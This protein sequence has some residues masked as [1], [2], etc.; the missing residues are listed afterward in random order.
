M[1]NVTSFYYHFNFFL[2][3]AIIENGDYGVLLNYS[4]VQNITCSSGFEA[5]ISDCTVNDAPN[6]CLPWCPNR[7]I[8]LRCFTGYI[9]KWLV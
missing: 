6:S 7:N 2:G 8:G 1:T 3:G 9:I 4:L 5:S